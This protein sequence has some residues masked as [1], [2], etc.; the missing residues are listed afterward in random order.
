MT[1][2]STLDTRLR[3]LVV[4][5]HDVVHWGLR[6]MLDRLQWVERSWSAR[7]GAEALELAAANEIELALVDLFVG[8]ESGAEICERLHVVRPGLKVLLISGAG[9]ISARAAASCGASGFITKD[10]RGADL[11]RAVQMVAMGLSV[12]EHDEGAMVPRPELSDRERQVL[13][14]LAAGATNREIAAGLHLSPHTVKE[15][16]SGVYRKL[17]VR[18]RIQ[19]AKRAEQLGLI[20]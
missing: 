8:T 13:A 5:D 11:V 20:D 15:Y 9:H 12:F 19:A 4:D 16:A 2:E 7:S 14:Q 6:I 1:A 17:G 3:V 10:R 18:G